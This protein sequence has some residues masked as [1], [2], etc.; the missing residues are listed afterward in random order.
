[1]SSYHNSF[2]YLGK[3]SKDDFGWIICHFSD[4]ADSG[5]T[6]TFLSTSAIYSDSYD[7]TRQRFYGTKYD[8]VAEVQITVIKQDGTN[9]GIDDNRQAL[10]WLT[11]SR[12]ATWMDFYIDEDVR[13]RLLGY[14]KSVSQ[15]KM[16][17][18]IIG[19]IITFASVSPYGY[20]STQTVSQTCTG[21]ETLVISC[22]SDDLYS[23][24]QMNTK[25]K[26]TGSSGSALTITNSTTGDVT[27][28]TGLS[29]NE[30]VTIS[31]NMV[32]TS[33]KSNKTF[34]NTFNFVFP[35][36]VAGNNKLTINGTGKITFEYIAPVKLGN[37]AIDIN[38][39][40]DPICDSE[41]NIQI[42]MLSWNRITNTPNTL[43]GYG[44]S[45]AYTKSEVDSKIANVSVNNVY[46][47]GEIDTMLKDFV[48]D[49]VY[50]KT[51]LD[52]KVQE[53]NSTI[54]DIQTNISGNY[55]TK[56]QMS[57]RYYTKTKIDT[58]LGDLA[59]DVYT[60]EETDVQVESINS[61]I[62]G[63]KSSVSNN[64]YSKSY[65]NS[66]YDT[67]SDVDAKIESAINSMDIGINQH[68]L[69]AMIQEILGD[70]TYE[71]TS[72]TSVL[73][74]GVLGEIILGSGD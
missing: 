62:S 29:K 13:Y 23:Y 69:S 2:S 68:A 31:D 22:D 37:I 63:I 74:T 61:E 41:G 34:G 4:N 26:N 25:F 64:Y 14:V 65:I 55:Y 32:I 39:V 57:S 47:K 54:S 58:M 8:S 27:E 21:T 30:T 12:Q 50:T 60:K 48:S 56:S 43:S 35:R 51:E 42:E 11:G 18:R 9:F 46:T 17:S 38:A 16:D 72:G 52:S 67:K 10:R 45:N 53:I 73:G 6:D 66:K 71:P 44:I 49:D 15:Y 20:S 70:L 24:V 5:E 33:D 59:E 28:I 1:M 40:S 3:N 36:L 7:G 19:F